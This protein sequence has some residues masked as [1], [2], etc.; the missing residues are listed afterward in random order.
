MGRKSTQQPPDI[1]ISR[2]TIESYLTLIKKLISGNS[3][4]TKSVRK[5]EGR[6]SPQLSEIKN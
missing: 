1:H 3:N 2:N 6:S 4:Y 5:F